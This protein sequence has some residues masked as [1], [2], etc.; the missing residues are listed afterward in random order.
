[1]KSVYRQSEDRPE[2]PLPSSTPVQAMHA[3]ELLQEQMRRLHNTRARQRAVRHPRA[4]R[5]PM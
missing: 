2:A 4:A 1:M 3:D 5:P